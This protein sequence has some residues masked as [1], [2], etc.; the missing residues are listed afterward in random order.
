MELKDII[1]RY[2]TLNIY[3]ERFVADNYYE[4][5]FYTKDTDQWIKLLNEI[6][7]SVTKPVGAAPSAED[8][9]LTKKYGGVRENQTLYK[10]QV[11]NTII[12][13]MLWP[14]QDEVRTTLKVAFIENK[15]L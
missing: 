8:A 1:A 6:F 5:V 15:P 4:V 9:E 14:W 2:K 7:G 12:A 13:A 10:K 11:N 3:E